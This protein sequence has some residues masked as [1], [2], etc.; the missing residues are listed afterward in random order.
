[1][2]MANNEGDARSILARCLLGQHWDMLW[3]PYTAEDLARIAVYEI[4]YLRN[5]LME[6]SGV[7]DDS[8]TD[9]GIDHSSCH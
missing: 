8:R 7:T 2:G 3:T 6:V 5:R 4:Q 9:E 1:M